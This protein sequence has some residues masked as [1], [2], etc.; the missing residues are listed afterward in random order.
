MEDFSPR[1]ESE[2]VEALEFD[3]AIE[4]ARKMMLA[5]SMNLSVEMLADTTYAKPVMRHA[6][7]Q[8]STYLFC[9][10]CV[11]SGVYYHRAMLGG[12]AMIVRA[13]NSKQAGQMAEEG[14]LSTVVLA[15]KWVSGDRLEQPGLLTESY[16][17]SKLN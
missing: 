4:K 2:A 13:E 1:S 11:L 15:R 17:R 9:V 12:H 14:L 8:Y 3:K 6:F 7:P 5:E 10:E 16:A